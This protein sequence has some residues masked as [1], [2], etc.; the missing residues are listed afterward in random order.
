MNTDFHTVIQVKLV[1]TIQIYSIVLIE[2]PS[3]LINLFVRF[4]SPLSTRFV[5]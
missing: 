1:L 5:S 2:I 4:F 3:I